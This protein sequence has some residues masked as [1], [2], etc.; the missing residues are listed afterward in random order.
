MVGKAKQ[1]QSGMTTPVY[2]SDAEC[3]Y[4]PEEGPSPPVDGWLYTLH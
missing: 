2:L 3:S 4:S 1:K